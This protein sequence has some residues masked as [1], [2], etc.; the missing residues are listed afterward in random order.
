MVY[1]LDIPSPF[2]TPRGCEA[3][4]VPSGPWRWELL[5]R[6]MPRLSVPRN[7]ITCSAAISGSVAARGVAWAQVAP[8]GPGG[9][10]MSWMWLKQCHKPI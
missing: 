4:A 6:E 1:H 8:G 10:E 7:I 9:L 2:P 5:F 3:N